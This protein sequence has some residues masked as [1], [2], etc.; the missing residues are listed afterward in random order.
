MRWT[1]S[2]SDAVY[3]DICEAEDGSMA[4]AML[5]DDNKADGHI[6]GIGSRS[7]TVP[8]TFMRRG[9]AKSRQGECETRLGAKTKAPPIL[10][11]VAI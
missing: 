8:V 7:I 4:A 11:V 6:G 10:T 2:V 9:E 1:S 3:M 5:T